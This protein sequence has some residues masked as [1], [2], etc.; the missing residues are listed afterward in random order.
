MNAAWLEHIRVGNFGLVSNVHLDMAQL[1][2]SEGRYVDAIDLLCSVMAH[3]LSGTG[4]NYNHGLFLEIGARFLFP[5]EKS[6]ATIP[7]GIITMVKKWQKKA[8]L[9]EEQLQDLLLQGF[10]RRRESS[11]IELFTPEESLEI[12][13][14]EYAGNKAGLSNIYKKA[15]NRFYEKYP[16]A[17]R[18]H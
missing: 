4:N 10:S 11:P 12:F 8:S 16:T 18:R 2:A 5:Y 17:G 15:E 1:L 14:M 9:D 13:N 7:P 6:L 3:N